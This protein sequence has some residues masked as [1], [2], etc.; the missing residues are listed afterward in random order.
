MILSPSF[1]QLG[2]NTDVMDDKHKNNEKGTQLRDLAEEYKNK[3]R[4]NKAMVKDSLR[5]SLNKK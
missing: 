5:D 1:L 2:C 3:K 4:H